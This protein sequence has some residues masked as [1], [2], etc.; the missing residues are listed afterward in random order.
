MNTDNGT[1]ATMDPKAKDITIPETRVR[2]LTVRI[3]GQ[4]PLITHRFGESAMDKIIH[5]QAGGAKVTPGV[6][7]PDRDARECLYLFDE[8]GRFDLP[9]SELQCGFPAPGLKKALVSAAI[10]GSDLKGTEVRAGLSVEADLLRIVS[11]EPPTIR[12]DHVVLPRTGGGIAYRPQFWPWS[13]DV[14]L[15][16][17]T[18]VM[19]V[20]Q[21]LHL[22]SLAGVT[23]GIG[24][25]RAEKSGTFGSFRLTAAVER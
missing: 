8:A 13:M 6:R 24:D 18:D 15:A 20:E 12:T 7:D 17:V 22:L 3:E 25:W 19:S 14:P 5:K 16:V 2:R 9:W 23:V 11:A 10:R 4:S 21:V 1:T